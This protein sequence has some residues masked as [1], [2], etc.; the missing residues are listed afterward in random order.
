LLILNAVL[1]AIAASIVLFAYLSLQFQLKR[2]AESYSDG[3]VVYQTE[4]VGI[5]GPAWPMLAYFVVPNV[6]MLL[7]LA[8]RWRSQR[9]ASLSPNDPT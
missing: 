4:F 5:S 8:Y 1:F 7:Y 6:L 9:K 3:P 2:E